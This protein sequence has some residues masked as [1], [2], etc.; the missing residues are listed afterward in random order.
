M[1]KA[2]LA[3]LF[4]L[5]SAVALAGFDTEPTPVSPD[6]ITRARIDL[7]AYLHMKNTGGWGPF[8]PG[9]GSGLCVFTSI[10]VGSRWQNVSELTG[11]QKY[12]TFQPG[13]GW[14]DKVDKTLKAFCKKK[15]VPV[16][17]YVQHTGGD[18]RFLELAVKTRRMACVTYAGMD[19]Y[20]NGDIAHMV[21][22]AHLDKDRA[23]IIDNN[24]PGKWVWMTRDEFEYRWHM[25]TT[26]HGWA[27]VLL[28][29]PP[30]P[31]ED[32]VTPVPQ[33]TPRKPKPNRPKPWRP[34]WETIR[35][36]N[37]DYIW[38]LYDD[39]GG[40]FWGTWDEH[41]W[42]PA[43]DQ[44]SWTVEPQGEAPVVPPAEIAAAEDKHY[45]I[46]G[47]EVPADDMFGLL[48]DDSTKY[49]LTV[50]VKDEDARKT[51]L[52]AAAELTSIETVHFNVYTQDFWA[53]KRVKHA[54][55]VQKP[56]DTADRTPLFTSEDTSAETVLEALKRADPKW[57][58]P[59][60]APHE[61]TPPV[62]PNDQP[63]PQ[64]SP[65]PNPTVPAGPTSPKVTVP[66]WLFWSAMAGVGYTLYLLLRR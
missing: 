51:V 19:N 38:K 52:E 10:E 45:F 41:G 66:T 24:R 48:K 47:Q 35:L 49:F 17:L 14:P 21:D 31:G 5:C 28:A 26:G 44:T 25:N 58:E 8:G 34:R 53:A 36:G 64:P 54:V 18:M 22:L 59:A 46:R 56:F 4:C 23:A 55:T 3:L 37:G 57:V 39:R 63:S 40:N 65:A 42:H 2:L 7:P 1:K 30:P 60:P 61:P 11:F 6:G 62:K 20:Y 16:P 15:G 27:F 12:M 29:P 43:V 13:G 33:P 50:V 9:S 32:E